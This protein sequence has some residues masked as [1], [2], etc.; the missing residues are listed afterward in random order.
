MFSLLEGKGGTSF[1]DFIVGVGGGGL[2]N[3]PLLLVSMFSVMAVGG[4]VTY[5]LLVFSMFSLLRV[6]VCVCAGVGGGGAANLSII[7]ILEWVDEG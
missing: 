4:D 7:D 6:C 1:Y 2:L 5:Q 3:I